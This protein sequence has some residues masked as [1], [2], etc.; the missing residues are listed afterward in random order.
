M[1]ARP[2]SLL[3]LTHRHNTPSLCLGVQSSKNKDMAVRWKENWKPC[4]Y[5]LLNFSGSVVLNNII[6]INQFKEMVLKIL[7]W[8]LQNSELDHIGG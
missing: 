3:N 4:S 7:V 5:A 6:I 8:H 1:D 2:E